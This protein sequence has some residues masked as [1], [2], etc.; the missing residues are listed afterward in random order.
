MAKKAE[1][2]AES[3]DVTGDGEQLAGER[4]FTQAE[5]DTIIA[6]RLKRQRGQYSDYDELRAQAEKWAEHEEAQK[7]EMQKALEAQAKAEAQAQ[8]VMER[9]NRR[10]IRAEFIAQAS[11]LNVQHPADA[12][13]LADRSAVEVTEDG[14]VKGV[15]AAVKQ[16]VDDGRL[17]LTTKA[18]AP[19]LDGGAGSGERAGDSKPLTEEEKRTAKKMGLTPEQ[20][21]AGKR[22][23]S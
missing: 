15:K 5:L 8:A 9:A 17:P 1:T 18:K 13:A 2:G 22:K 23:E 11:Q 7:S 19:D 6:D 12:F 4:T 16:L 21:R 3:P 10:L 14:K 20:Y